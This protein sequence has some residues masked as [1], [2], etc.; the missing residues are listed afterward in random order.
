[1]NAQLELITHIQIGVN[2]YIFCFS[3]IMLPYILLIIIYLNMC[4]QYYLCYNIYK[5]FLRN[6]DVCMYILI[7]TNHQISYLPNLI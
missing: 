1:M 5:L 6:K 2:L 4:N 3:N 7:I